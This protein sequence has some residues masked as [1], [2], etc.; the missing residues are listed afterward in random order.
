[1]Q[2]AAFRND[3]LLR[4]KFVC[5]FTTAILFFLACPTS[6]LDPN[7]AITQY[8]H[9]I[10]TTD[11]GLPENT[12]NSILRTRDGYI[13]I[14]T[15][16]GLARFDGVRFTVFNKNNTPILG[17]NLFWVLFEG[18]DDTLWI[19]TLGAGLYAVNNGHWRRFTT[20]EGL[21]NDTIMSL[22][23]DRYGNLWIGTLRG[24]LNKLKDGKFTNYTTKE[25]LSSEAVLSIYE[26]R[27]ANLW[28]GTGRGLN[29]F[30]DG[31]FTIYTTKEG[32]SAD[33]IKSLYEDREGDLWIGTNGG[34]LNKLKDG[35]FTSYSTKD[36]LLNDSVSWTTGDRDGNLWIGTSGGL[37]RLKAGRFTS[38]TAKDG[39]SDNTVLFLYEDVE[40]NLWIGTSGGLNRLRDGKFTTFTTPEGLSPGTVWSVFEDHA[41]GIWIG[42]SDGLNRLKDGKFSSYTAADGLSGNSVQSVYEDRQENLWVGI[43]DGGLNRLRD[44][45]FTV[46]TVKEGMLSNQ[47]YALYED[48]RRNL[49]IG[50]PRGLNLLRDGYTT[51]DGLADGQVRA[52][53]EDQQGNL[54]IGTLAGL[55]QLRNG[56]LTRY[57]TKE[58]LSSDVVFALYA[59]LEENLWIG[60]GGGLTRLKNGKFTSVTSSQGLLSDGIGSIAEDNSGNLWMCSVGGIFS[61]SKK[62]FNELAEGKIK[63]IH[64]TAYGKGDGL[65]SRGCKGGQQPSSWKTRDG[66]L[67]FCSDQGAAVIDPKNIRINAR[68]P[69]VIIEG[70]VA[71]EKPLWSNPVQAKTESRKSES[72]I[73]IAAGKERFQFTY[74]ALSFNVPERVKFR[75]MLEGLDRDWTNAGT[76]RSADYTNLPPGSY[77]F[78]VKAC[79]EDGVWNEAGAS[80][81]FYLEPH[82]Y[83]TSWFYGLCVLAAAASIFGGLRL[84][85]RQLETRE[86]D[87]I[88]AVERGTQDLREANKKLQEAE[89]RIL[90]MADSGPR[91]LENLPVWSRIVAQEVA[92]V[93]GAQEIGIWKIEGEELV[94]LTASRSKPPALK[95][96]RA[97]SSNFVV[98]EKEIV[99]PVNGIT[100][101]IFGVLVVTGSNLLLG[102]SER[103]LVAAF[104]HQLGG[105]LEMEQ[106]RKRL[107]EAEQQKSVTLQELQKQGIATLQ[108]CSACGLCYDHTAETCEADGGP[109]TVPRVLPYRILERY[110]LKRFLGEGAM[111]AVF[112]A[113]DEKLRRDVSL[114]IVRA[115]LLSDSL[116]RIRIRREAQIIAQLQHPGVISIYDFGE[117]LDGSAF[118]VMEFLK[119]VD[120]Q[121]VLKREGRGSPQQVARVLLQVGEAL[122]TTHSRGVIHRDLKPSNLFVV[123]SD[124][125]FQVK[126]LDFGLAKS[127]IN[128]V[129]LTATG[130]VVGTPSYMSPEQARGQLMD[131]QSDLFSLASLTYELLTED[132]PFPGD[133]VTDVMAKIL[134]EKPQPLSSKLPGAPVELDRAFFAAMAKDPEDRPRNLLQWTKQVASLLQQ[135]P[136]SVPGWRFASGLN[137]RPH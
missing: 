67:W 115:E 25:G 57:T 68:A 52:M 29:M 87:L 47:V 121:K 37:N 78:R 39:L 51:K 28:I 12:V 96:L 83:Q 92:R 125:E 3:S 137:R 50:T 97:A 44:G 60:T 81:P 113:E 66:K 15:W 32:L 38:L 1:M 116:M 77:R 54:W 70:I 120:L 99:V 75:F 104:A 62:E 93:I 119:G 95:D 27:K 103:H 89:A 100:G 31:K 4:E 132:R 107:G 129:S 16:D 88:V 73:R 7:K 34:G 74:T 71:D 6:A 108:L 24:G 30:R 133:S 69:A 42:T 13:W 128:D 122:H 72:S 53:Y 59:D 14:A 41:A 134:N 36:G 64:S 65:K 105:A 11:N 130:M 79:N 123:P 101:D 40:Q 112:E 102:D 106:M 48:S 18:R 136:S 8:V 109:L 56:K 118:M 49:W 43:E 17:N 135:I 46:Y 23:E 2:L 110:R 33:S 58:G 22:H 20:D 126:V 84:R 86:R 55:T 61:I 127:V 35:K 111:G 131:E 82:F 45:K 10:W 124:S 94:P 98:T 21:S 114:K 91:A 117:L 90:K 19:G 85:V 76:H 80:I 9:D 63:S 26:D 5:L